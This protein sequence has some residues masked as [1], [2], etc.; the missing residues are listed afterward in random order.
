MGQQ[1]PIQGLK[2]LLI[3]VC[4]MGTVMP[5]LV[6]YVAQQ[7]R[8]RIIESERKGCERRVEDRLSTI[9]VWEA[10][11]KAAKTIS[12]DKFQSQKTRNARR[13]EAAVLW[14]SIQDFKRRTTPEYGGTLNCEDAYPNTPLIP[15]NY[16]ASKASS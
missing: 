9:S 1:G 6:L 12:E 2:R 11:Y 7:G 14:S 8:E 10:Q 3:S 4:L 13:E 5:I 15:V 16:S